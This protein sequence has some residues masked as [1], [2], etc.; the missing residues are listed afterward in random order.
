MTEQSQRGEQPRQAAGEGP[1]IVI[2]PGEGL[3]G[4]DA[5][6][7]A[8]VAG[9]I[10]GEQAS[11]RIAPFAEPDQVARSLRVLAGVF[12]L[13]AN[14]K[15]EGYDTTDPRAYADLIADPLLGAA[16]NG[17]AR[18]CTKCGHAW[19]ALHA[20]HLEREDLGGGVCPGCGVKY[21]VP[22]ARAAADKALITP[23]P[24]GPYR[25][26]SPFAGWPGPEDQPAATS[27]PAPAPA[28]DDAP[29]F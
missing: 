2:S 6:A 7:W 1:R 18:I 12:A 21:V 29:L 15:R 10:K 8:L 5:G 19:S 16:L 24:T 28:A 11:V 22:E 23:A 17:A 26:P 4:F 27:V 20:P 3:V 13:A 14:A 25:T 9:V